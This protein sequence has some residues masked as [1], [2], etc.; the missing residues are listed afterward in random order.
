M[1]SFS[2]RFTLPK[3]RAIVCFLLLICAQAF[4]QV[5]FSDSEDVPFIVQKQL[6][7]KT[8]IPKYKIK[9][10]EDFKATDWRA[11]IDS[12][13]G[14]GLPTDQ[15]L[16]IFDS[17]WGTIDSEFAC[18][19]DLNVNWDSLR[20][21]YRTE[22]ANNVSRGRFAAMMNQLALSLKEAH[23]F[24]DDKV[25]NWNTVAGPG[26]PLLIVGGW[27]NNGHFGAGL[28]P[29]PDSSLLIYKAVSSHPLGLEPGDIIL[30]YDGIPWKYLYSDLIKAQLPITGWWWGCSESAYLH[31]WLMSAGMNWHLFDVIDIVKFGSGDTLHLSTSVLSNQSMNLFCSEQLEIPGVPMLDME[32]I[33]S[34]NVVSTGIVED[35]QIGYVY[36]WGWYGNVETAFFDAID[37]L[38]NKSATTGL[39]IDFRTNYGGNMFLS[40]K[41]LEL[42]FNSSVST[43][44]FARRSDPN[45][46]F[47]ME[48]STPPSVYVI[49]G[50]PESYYDQPIAVLTGPGAVSSGDQVA[51]R[52]QFHPRVRLFGKSTTAAFNAPTQ[53]NLGNDNWSARYAVADAYLVTNPGHYLTHD[54]FE[55]DEEVWL[56]PEDVAQG[57]DTVVEAAIKWI[58]NTTTAVSDPNFGAPP[59]TFSL[60]QNYPNPFN[61]TTTIHFSLPRHSSV[62]LQIYDIRGREVARVVDEELQPGEHR[63]AFDAKGLPSGV[64]LYRIKLEGFN[65][66][67][68]MIVLK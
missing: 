58:N 20:T 31:S 9:L 37:S 46:H 36:V 21:I 6:A 29:L 68:K 18:F 26:V 47:A 23:T 12:T 64:Y 48:S 15:K 34:G 33:Y 65:R 32:E 62:K 24:I 42:L 35:T 2:L 61:P 63:I 54:E 25:V 3:I 14:E 7:P 55:V 49:N 27:G 50:N 59:G 43:I 28:T 19:Q 38:M 1:K 8:F 56:N 4:G 41:A 44:G 17:F 45:N 30:G 67:K 13:W 10:R 16:Q 53:L 66:I 52:M 5:L 51:L 57:R 40:N 39:I 60:S 11:L 22:V